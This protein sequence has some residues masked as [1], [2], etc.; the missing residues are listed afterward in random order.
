MEGTLAEEKQG[1]AQALAP[2]EGEAQALAPQEGEADGQGEEDLVEEAGSSQNP[3]HVFALLPWTG[4]SPVWH[5]FAGLV[6]PLPVA[7]VHA[8]LEL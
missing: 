6:A 2:Q 3:R 4:T 7:L 1:E 5:K 8:I